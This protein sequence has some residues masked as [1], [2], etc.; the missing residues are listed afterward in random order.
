FLLPA[1]QGWMAWKEGPNAHFCDTDPRL[2]GHPACSPNATRGRRKYNTQKFLVIGG[3]TDV[4]NPDYNP[5]YDP[6]TDEYFD[7]NQNPGTFTYAADPG[8]VLA[9]TPV[10]FDPFL[11]NGDT[12]F[13]NIRGPVWWMNAYDPD[14]EFDLQTGPG[15]EFSRNSLDNSPLNLS[16]FNFVCSTTVGFSNLDPSACALNI[17]SSTKEPGGSNA[18]APRIS[19]VISAF[20][21][22]DPGFNGFLGQVASDPLLSKGTVMPNKMGMPLVQL[23]SD[24]EIPAPP[25]RLFPAEGL[26]TFRTWDV[27][28]DWQDRENLY[29]LPNNPNNPN[30]PTAR[31]D[32]Y[33]PWIYTREAESYN[34]LPP[35]HTT[36]GVGTIL[37][38]GG[39]AINMFKNQGDDGSETNAWRSRYAAGAF[40]AK[41]LTPEQEALAGCGPYFNINC[42]ANG[43]DLLWAEGSALLQ[44]ALGSDSTGISMVKLG[45]QDLVPASFGRMFMDNGSP[46]QEYRTDGR[47]IDKNGNLIRI[48]RLQDGGEPAP[49]LGSKG[50]IDTASSG[51][52]G[53]SIG[54]PPAD[55]VINTDPIV[56]ENSINA[57]RGP[58]MLLSD[59]T[60]ARCWDLRRYF[61][62]YGV[63]PGTASFEA[64][65]LG[66]P[67]CTTADLGGP[68]NPNASIL[69][70]CRNKWDTI[71]YQPLDSW[72]GV[73]ELHPNNPDAGYIGNNFY[74]TSVFSYKAD[75][76][77]PNAQLPSPRRDYR[78][79][80]KDPSNHVTG[81][82]DLGNEIDCG[83]GTSAA[84]GSITDPQN[85]D[86]YLFNPV[87]NGLSGLGKSATVRLDA[88]WSS[89]DPRYTAAQQSL[90]SGLNW[91]VYNP[92][93]AGCAN[94]SP[95]DP[96]C[97]L[98]GW[99]QTVDGNPD[100]LGLF[101]NSG[102]LKYPRILD[103][104]GI[105]DRHGLSDID[106][107]DPTVNPFGALF[108]GQRVENGCTTGQSWIFIQ[109]TADNRLLKPSECVNT[110][111]A[112]GTLDNGDTIPDRLIGGT[113][114]PFT[115]E[116]FSS[117]ISGLSWNLMMI[118]VAFSDDFTDGLA[119][120]RGYVNP[121]VYESRYIYDEEWM[122]NPACDA[123]NPCN[124]RVFIADPTPPILVPVNHSVYGDPNRDL[125]GNDIMQSPSTARIRQVTGWRSTGIANIGL[126]A[127][128][129]A[130]P[131]PLPSGVQ[132]RLQRDPSLPNIMTD[133]PDLLMFECQS[134]AEAL[135]N[136]PTLD[137]R[138]LWENCG[139]AAN[140]GESDWRRDGTPV[141]RSSS[142]VPFAGTNYNQRLRLG[143]DSIEGLNTGLVSSMLWDYAFTG[144]ENDLLAMIPYCE[145][146]EFSQR[147]TRSTTGDV[148]Y[149]VASGIWG[150]SR[151]DCSKARNP[152]GTIRRL[153]RKRCTFVTPQY[154]DVVQAIF[155]IAGQ[156]RNIPQAGGNGLYGRRTTQWQSGSEI[157]LSYDKR[158]VLGFS[159]D[160]A[161]DYT[162]S[163]WS[164]E[165]TW[166]GDVP[167]INNN[168]YDI[169][170][171]TDDFN[172]TISVDR[173][174]FVN[175]LNANRTFFINSQWFFQYRKGWESGMTNPGPWNV[176]ATFAVFT[177]YFQDRLNPTLVFVYD[178]QSRSGGALPQI[179]YR[180]SENFSV[181]LGASLF[182]GGQDL[183][184][185]PVNPIAPAVPRAGSNTYYD[186]T[187]PGLS[188]VRDRDEVFMTLRYTF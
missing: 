35:S 77:T 85:Y 45:I 179:N 61:V 2:T 142:G 107:A 71:A 135:S 143:Y 17:F 157:Y 134:A 100:P 88:G 81:T 170:T 23:H 57:F 125:D 136:D 129:D 140:G 29:V 163:N 184:V 40:L 76:F 11:V 55:C 111:T 47:A 32:Q 84:P 180:F 151:I 86:C 18:S 21:A 168:A 108:Y 66:S 124:G 162:K 78:Q 28:R 122:W 105:G 22:G 120:V 67:K 164:M 147:H 109:R 95:N 56:D 103:T 75:I 3:D 62:A 64:L 97:Y 46:S 182:M 160:F 90:R 9:A 74:A 185:M 186:S 159:M 25:S 112:P 165:F 144:T 94:P 65:R 117:E 79:W 1:G 44:S 167:Q 137:L 48:S 68:S 114:H 148:G 5:F 38:C 113:G 33:Y 34:C 20:M 53:N 181:T 101:D 49:V 13:K 126:A 128:P 127:R 118:L 110:F 183:V 30:S 50:L 72:D 132:N 169:T 102:G 51:L 175:F 6:R 145:N 12:V 139:T 37:L 39:L 106:L 121:E 138:T 16:V 171:D 174:T 115:G 60:S 187:E 173:P 133:F 93:V 141:P 52:N 43:A 123:T 96:D 146:L 150:Q 63:I 4:P 152:D 154:C 10:R 176:L 161:E 54:L 178:F 73:S 131:N 80:S 149:Q 83:N 155:S 31:S 69:P 172:L 99:R 91:G 36:K 98:G 166:I 41:A 153:G 15:G 7:A 188:V 59:R 116:S 14:L 42:D 156:K 130:I 92:R 177:G 158:N 8:G 58:G 119:S 89:S 104:L 24:Y 82:T 70:G 27:R 26:S 87:D 19:F